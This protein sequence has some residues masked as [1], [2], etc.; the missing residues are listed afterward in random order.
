MMEWLLG[1]CCGAG[2]VLQWTAPA[3]VP[4]LTG[5]TSLAVLALAWRGGTSRGSSWA[6]RAVRG[7]TQRTL[8]LKASL[9]PGT[10]AHTARSTLY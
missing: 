4:L 2:G 5:G 1:G 10:H 6:K 9:P 3:W 8:V 7:V